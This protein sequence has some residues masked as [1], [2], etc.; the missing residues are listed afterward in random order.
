MTRA[1]RLAE[2][3]D[4]LVW[5]GALS[6]ERLPGTDERI[7]SIVDRLEAL[8]G[9]RL[10]EE[11][12]RADFSGATMVSKAPVFSDDRVRVVREG[13]GLRLPG[14]SARQMTVIRKAEVVPIDA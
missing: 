1:E 7:S 4:L 6:T 9:G 2:V 11:G 14:E 3:T 10:Y 5:A 12:L 8:G 13:Y